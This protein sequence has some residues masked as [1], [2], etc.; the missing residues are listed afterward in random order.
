MSQSGN[1]IESTFA[2]AWT[3]L[4]KNPVIVLPGVLL[5]VA[6]G[7]A[8]IFIV[9]LVLSSVAV[10][11]ATGSDAAGWTAGVVT[12]CIAIAMVMVLVILQMAFVT[13]MAGAAWRSGTATIADGWSAFGRRGWHIVGAMFLLSWIGLV[14]LIFAPFTLLLSLL[15]FAVF[16]VYVAPAVVVG[17]RSATASIAESCR[18]A[19]RNLLP[20]FAIV[21]ILVVVAILAAGA[22]ELFAKVTP[23]FALPVAMIVQQAAVA[24]ATLVITG[25]YLKLAEPSAP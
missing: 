5:G 13:G 17:E 4:L 3:L 19:G 25:E 1:D 12:A 6:G 23:L 8:A 7:F 9:G 18:L 15:A 24:Y 16:F 2:Q 22:G 10:G 11:L 14:A 21:A 20:A